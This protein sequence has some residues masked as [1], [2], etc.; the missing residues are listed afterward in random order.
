MATDLIVKPLS[1]PLPS[2]VST[3]ALGIYPSDV[4]LRTAII[5]GIADMR[6][7]PWLLD[8]CFAALAQ[9]TL[10]LDSYGEKAVSE[11]KKWFLANE[12]S[13]VLG[14]R[15]PDGAPKPYMVAI[16]LQGSAEV[17]NTLSDI[18]PEDREDTEAESPALTAKFT[19]ASYDAL[20]GH[21][22]LPDNIAADTP[23]STIMAV[24]DRKG[25]AHQ[26]LE[27][28]SDKVVRVTKGT[29]ADFV[30]CYLRLR[31]PAYVTHLETAQFKETYL[32][33][34]HAHGEPVFLTYLYSVVL[35]CL[36]RY[37]QELLE[38]RGLERSTLS[39]ADV[40]IDEMS[41]TEFYHTRYITLNGIVRHVWP[42]VASRLLSVTKDVGVSGIRTPSDEL[43]DPDAD[44]L[45]GRVER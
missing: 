15:I 22:T 3:K 14:A 17:E 2:T 7:N 19:P 8:Y 23:P 20:T 32:I 5:A 37:R 12:I 33:G 30:D 45:T 35:F 44:V 41:N 31:I 34:C 1:L 27:V 42:K 26:I 18:N 9:D 6:A 13:V 25:V 28:V 4:I 11:A 10:T 40:T 39:A 24:V 38:A 16:H 21:L 43:V 29:V 36:L